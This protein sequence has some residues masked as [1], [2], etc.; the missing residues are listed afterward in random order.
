VPAARPGAPICG[1]CKRQLDLSGVPQDVNGA[2]LER[3]VSAS[4]VPVLVDFW[5]P[6]CGPCR[7]AAPLVDRAAREHAGDL[8]VLKLNSDQ[9]GESSARHGISGIPAFVVFAHGSE[10]ARQVGLPSPAAFGAWVARA[11]DTR[12]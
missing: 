6:W 1:K 12:A 2:E 5:A 4:P 10:V 3:V 11:K 7:M 8:I 9:N